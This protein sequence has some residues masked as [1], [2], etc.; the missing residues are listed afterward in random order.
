MRL[1]LKAVRSRASSGEA[2]EREK[3]RDGM[4]CERGLK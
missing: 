4:L 3:E 2:G 1:D